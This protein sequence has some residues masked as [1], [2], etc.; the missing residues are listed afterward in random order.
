MVVLGVQEEQEQGGWIKGGGMGN[1]QIPPKEA[2]I[3]GH[4]VQSRWDPAGPSRNHEAGNEG[5][6]A[7]ST[8]LL[9][10]ATY[11]EIA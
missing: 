10:K 1:V 8:S 2:E 4:F 9:Q 11:Q 7:S 5:I 6:E 3:L